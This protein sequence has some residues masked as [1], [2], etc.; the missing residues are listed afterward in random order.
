MSRKWYH[1]FPV[2][3][4]LIS[5]FMPRY[6]GEDGGGDPP[7]NLPEGFSIDSL[8]GE[9]WANIVNERFKDNTVALNTKSPLDAIEQLTN[10]QKMIG[11]KRLAEPQEDWK[12]EDW[13][14]F[15]KALGRP[16]KPEEYKLESIPD[17]I[18][19]HIDPEFMKEASAQLHAAGL[20]GKQYDKAMGAYFAWLEKATTT[21]ND[22]AA[23]QQTEAEEK[24]RKELGEEYDGKVTRANNVIATFGDPE[25]SKFLAESGLG[26]N[27]GFIKMM[28]GIADQ[29]KDDEALGSSINSNLSAENAAKKEIADMKSD[30]DFQKKLFDETN[31]G[32]KQ[33][34]QKW[35]DAH[36]KAYPGSQVK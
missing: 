31:P 12:E 3:S 17:S 25:T 2:L 22:T 8:Q 30:N 35:H 4:S 27:P 33:A 6:V 13:N 29:F 15:Y 1:L 9:A 26:N 5:P 7:P 19:E 32:H 18:K 36:K 34:V 21:A 23:A 14:N 16:D 24:L 10:A 11:T 20:T 28:M